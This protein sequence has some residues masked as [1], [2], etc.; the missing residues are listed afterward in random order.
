MLR[1]LNIIAKIEHLFLVTFKQRVA[2]IKC[3]KHPKIAMLR[4]V[5]VAK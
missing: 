1:K 5:K 4:E 3:R 2:G